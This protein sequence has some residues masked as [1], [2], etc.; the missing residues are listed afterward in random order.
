MESS[1]GGDVPVGGVTV[2]IGR[3]IC[4]LGHLVEVLRKDDAVKGKVELD[5]DD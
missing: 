2:I 1:G 3:H 4:A 5:V